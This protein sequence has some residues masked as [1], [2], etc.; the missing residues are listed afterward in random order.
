MKSINKENGSLFKSVGSS[1]SKLNDLSKNTI[2]YVS[3]SQPVVHTVPAHHAV[4]VV[5]PR[6]RVV[7]HPEPV[8]VVIPVIE[9]KKPEVKPIIDPFK[10][11]ETKGIVIEEER[12]GVSFERQGALTEHN[13]LCH[14]ED[15]TYLHDVDFTLCPCNQQAAAPIQ[16]F[17]HAEERKKTAGFIWWLIPLFIIGLL[18]I[19]ILLALFYQKKSII[20]KKKFVI[21][22]VHKEHD[23]D[24][25]EAEIQR[26]L[27][28]KI[29]EKQRRNYDNEDVKVEQSPQAVGAG[30]PVQRRSPS[31]KSGEEGGSSK[32]VVKKR[33]VKMMKD[34][35]L[36]AEKE[37]ILDEEGNVLR[38]QIRK[39]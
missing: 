29:A 12:M 7:L 32:K 21:E 25:I 9:E 6:P 20:P 14:N 19:A 30:A 39:D 28:A 26:Q 27:E 5:E 2:S 31:N 3:T 24:E 35:V 37:E 1:N 36:I 8:A 34:G 4:H 33:I 10:D 23:E 18:L 13:R 15:S 16:F 11:E 38:T 17:E 22:K